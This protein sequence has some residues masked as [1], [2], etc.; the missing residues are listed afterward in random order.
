MLL[1]SDWFV[2]I[3]VFN[4]NQ[5]GPVAGRRLVV[6]YCQGA[7]SQRL[8]CICI[9]TATYVLGAVQKDVSSAV[10]AHTI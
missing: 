4:G 5:W 8:T 2:D 10:V 3:L 7:N 1:L 6:V 9:A